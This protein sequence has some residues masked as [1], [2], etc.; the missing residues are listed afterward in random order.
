MGSCKARKRYPGC[1]MLKMFTGAMTVKLDE[2]DNF[3]TNVHHQDHVKQAMASALNVVA[4]EIKITG[5]MAEEGSSDA[6]SIG[7]KVEVVYESSLSAKDISEASDEIKAQL[8][9]QFS[10][11]VKT[12]DLV[13]PAAQEGCVSALKVAGHPAGK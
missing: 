9:N 6:V 5:V 3:M 13:P 7:Y 12:I 4:S 11:G 1:P 8:N 2:K 10:T